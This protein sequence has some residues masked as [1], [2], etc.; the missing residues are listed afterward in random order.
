ME[1]K[2]GFNNR[3]V[4]IG[5]SSLL[6]IFT[7][8]CLVVFSTLSLASA[9]A[10]YRLAVKTQQSVKAYYAAD[11]RGEELKR[12]M[13]RKLIQLAKEA[14]S[15]EVFRNLVQQNFKQAF[16]QSSNQIS[17]AVDTGSGQLLRIQFQLLPYEEMEE[18]KANYK[19]LSWSIQNKE[20]YEVDSKMPVWNGNEDID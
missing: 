18:G 3:G 12:D 14:P 9:R 2:K 16:D 15:E 5:T 11:A 8:L 6:L 20:D 1:K 4:Q 13:N 10:D 7:V 19:I 17:Y